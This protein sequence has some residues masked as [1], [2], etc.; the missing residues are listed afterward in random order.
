MKSE[1]RSGPSISEAA[2]LTCCTFLM[3]NLDQ[4]LACSCCP[5]AQSSL[6]LQPHDCST[7]GLPVLQNL[8]EL[9][10]IHH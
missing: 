2:G 8:P 3:P 5:V 6:T 10:Q 9:A 7:S 4:T 1:N